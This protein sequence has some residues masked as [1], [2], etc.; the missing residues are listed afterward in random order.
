MKMSNLA[1]AASFLLFMASCNSGTDSATTTDSSTMVDNSTSMDTSSMMSD[2]SSMHM[3]MQM[4]VVMKDDKLMVMD[5]GTTT[6]M[7]KE[8]TMDDGTKVMTDGHY[9]KPGGE[10]VMMKNGD[11]IMKDGSVTTVDKMGM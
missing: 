7:D 4:C 11:C 3:P 1:V 5:N 10:K 9:M 2:T 8:M 6:P